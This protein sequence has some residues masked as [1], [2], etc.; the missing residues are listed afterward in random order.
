MTNFGHNA[1]LIVPK[2]TILWFRYIKLYLKSISKWDVLSNITN[3]V[4]VIINSLNG[5]RLAQGPSNR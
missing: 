3:R 5:D 4:V 1:V 2:A